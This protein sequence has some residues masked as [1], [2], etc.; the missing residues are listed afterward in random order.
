MGTADSYYKYELEPEIHNLTLLRSFIEDGKNDAKPL[1]VHLKF[2]SGMN[3]LGFDKKECNSVLQLWQSQQ[4]L[5]LASVMT[6]LSSSGMPEEDEFTLGQLQ[7]FTAIKKY[8]SPI[9]EG[10]TLF[11]CLNT[12]GTYRFPDYHMDMVRLGIGIYGSPS[13]P[14][15]QEHLQPIC[16]WKSRVAQVR[17]VLAGA[18]ISYARSGRLAQDANIATISMGYADGFHR[19]MGNGNWEVEI[20]GKLYPTVGNICMDLFMVNLGSDEAAVDSEVIIF[21]GKRS[22]FEFA[23]ANQTIT[24]EVM[25]NISGRVE[26]LFVKG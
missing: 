16:I 8:L 19:R 1:K 26:R 6:H 17:K 20:N 15:L 5:Q 10:Q 22:I 21:G 7:E 13:V 23:D 3:R 14:E 11:H 12:N 25:T 2:N 18:S 4:Q 24:Y 9:T